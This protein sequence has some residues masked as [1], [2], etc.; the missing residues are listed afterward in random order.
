[1]SLS[2]IEP[3][4]P[5]FV[6]MPKR[7]GATERLQVADGAVKVQNN[8]KV[9][10]L[11]NP[12]HRPRTR[13]WVKQEEEIR[14]AES[15]VP[16]GTI[17]R[18]RSLR[19]RGTGP[20]A[21]ESQAQQPVLQASP[22]EAQGEHNRGLKSKRVQPARSGTKRGTKRSTKPVSKKGQRKLPPIE[23]AP[24]RVEA[25]EKPQQI[26][27][28]GKQQDPNLADWLSGLEPVSPRAFAEDRDL[29]TAS[30]PSIP[31]GSESTMDLSSLPRDDESATTKG[32]GSGGKKLSIQKLAV[33]RIEDEPLE[34]PKMPDLRSILTL[35]LPERQL[36]DIGDL[37]SVTK[38]FLQQIEE[39]PN[40]S[41]YNAIDDFSYRFDE[42]KTSIRY[43]AI[44]CHYF[45][46][47]LKRCLSQNE[48]VLQRTIMI[49]IINQYWLD[50]KFDWNTE[51]QWSQTDAT[52][53]KSRDDDKISLPKPDLAISF[54][55]RS[56]STGGDKS[57]PVPRELQSSLSPDNGF[58]CFP[59]LFFEVKKAGAD[60]QDAFMANLHSA[61]QALN[62][63][64][65]WIERANLEE[66][67]S[68][69]VRVFS[70]VFNAQ[71]LGVRVHRIVK[72]TDGILSFQFDE[73]RPL[74]RYTKDQ[75]CV[76]I[77]SILVDYA[78]KELHSTLKRAFREVISRRLEEISSK[79]SAPPAR[80]SS[81][82]RT[83]RG[84]IDNTLH[85]GASFGLSQLE[86]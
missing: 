55:L 33:R 15:I 29:Y 47:D 7:R 43:P 38:D 48:A 27:E 31:D 39:H 9:N 37:K 72:R 62:N 66:E 5:P 83:R 24:K 46:A 41:C 65:T 18:R 52:C 6:S 85:T 30:R 56:L 76:L 84:D 69:D 20:D 63:M 4:Q 64:H 26:L 71:D 58:R 14:G 82:K 40:E 78:A 57:D 16:L 74:N 59:F 19:Q 49:H 36:K 12:P 79:R 11:P 80:N 60:L 13:A 54:K 50:E 10:K 22:G 2:S 8:Q 67:C 75:A 45:K 68:E 25:E 28:Q 70:V 3:A 77:Q 42:G 17:G 73:L 21:L 1:M 51:G 86:T 44:N 81:S 23:S 32:R 61:S 53:L 34:D 35:Q